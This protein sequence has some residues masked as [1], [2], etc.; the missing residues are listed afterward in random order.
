MIREV[1]SE[2]SPQVR[3]SCGDLLVEYHLDVRTRA[4]GLRLYPASEESKIV[5][6]R[7]YLET[8][9]VLAL[10]NSWRPI[11]AY[12]GEVSLIQLK[13]AE[14]ESLGAFS[15]G[16]SQRLNSTTVG[17]R[18]V[19]QNVSGDGSGFTVRTT[20]RGARSFL[21]V[22][23]LSYET[24]DAAVTVHG[25]FHNQGETPLT[26]EMISSFCFG[27]LSPFDKVDSSERLRLHRFRS[28]WSAEGRHE[29]VL[30]EDLHLERAWTNHGFASE[31]FGQ[32]GSM[33]LRGFASLA[34]IEDIPTGVFW[35]AQLACPASW[36]M[37]ICRRDD[38]VSLSG[39]LADREFGHWIKRIAAGET[40]RTPKA[41]LSTAVGNI[42]TICQ[43]LTRMGNKALRTQP[44][45][46]KE[47]PI[48]FNEWCS[49]W[50]QPTP[51]YILKTAERLRQMPV[52]I[53]VIDD[54]WIEKPANGFQFNGDW[55]V[56]EKRF[57][58]G[59]KAVASALAEKGFVPGLWFEFETCTEGTRAYSQEDHQL[60][61]DGRTLKIGNRHFWDFAD[62]WVFEYLGKK[63]IDR[64]K[65]DGFGY[66]KV[67]YNEALGIGC[68]HPDSLGEGLRLHLEGVQRFFR[69]LREEIPHLIIE[70]CSSG[71]HRLEPS[72]MELCAM[73]SFS[74]AHESPDIPLIAANLHRLILP[75]QLQIWAVLRHSDSRMRLQ[76]SLAA[77]FLGRACLS[78]EMTRLDE[79]QFQ[80]MRD[81]LEFYERIKF[82]IRDGESVLHRRTNKSYQHPKGWQAVVRT[83]RPDPEHCLV[84]FHAFADSTDAKAEIELPG[85]TPWRI[86][87][88]HQQGLEMQLADNGKLV[89]TVEQP[90]AAGVVWLRAE[91]L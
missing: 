57:P 5:P 63:V 26:L 47:L 9:E 89:V 16:R 39:G 21:C 73:G 59:L 83:S 10:P 40:F 58:N 20:L 33:P 43:R 18:F 27:F 6:H 32:V 3:Y 79:G 14:D 66:I 62:P 60:H 4:V 45:L 36:Q 19:D 61:F 76:Y 53:F 49:S 65:E 35:G 75:R 42:D 30:L 7:T 28:F 41:Y 90:F 72:L 15:V 46:E 13:L 38:K 54:G 17:L 74:D 51:D 56:D 11:P 52:K 87:E 71:G 88:P 22:H 81:Q 91:A 1:L 31:R 48:L 67:D 64:L 84:V 77:C 23:V 12:N 68:D 69:K 8:P 29:A 80:F 25:E 86:V 2:H 55:N 37:E 78:G 24:G 44:A 82:I 70:N 34:A 50:G 85:T